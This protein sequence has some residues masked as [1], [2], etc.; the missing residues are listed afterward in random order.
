MK[1]LFVVKR[2]I[3][4][5]DLSDEAFV[6]WCA[7]RSIMQK[8]IKEYF[9]SYSM[10]GYA[11][12]GKRHLTRTEI[13]IVKKGYNDLKEKDYIK[14]KFPINSNDEIV[15]LSEL[16]YEKGKGYFS[17]LTDVEMQKIMNLK[18]IGKINHCRLLRYFTCMVGT[19]NR[20]NDIG[21]EYKGK[22]GGMA[23][24][25]FTE[26][27]GVSNK[28][29]SQYNQ[30]L[31]DNELLFIVRHKDF[32]QGTNAKGQSELREIPNTYSRWC[33]KDIAKKFSEDIHGYKYFKEQKNIKTEKANKNRGLAQKYNSFCKGKE[34]DIETIKAIYIYCENWNKN[35]LAYHNTQISLGYKHELQQKDM[36]VF[37]KYLLKVVDADDKNVKEVI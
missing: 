10:I 23:L 12:H 25:C 9:V 24:D 4:D 6:V 29:A 35:Q 28:T 7:L 32:L 27:I 26:L 1:K 8:D 36:S 17:D 37:D 22:I 19:F 16:Y 14:L 20:S 18:N 15:D 13:N 21:S 30:I 33:D 34:Y 3:E 31:E 2:V 11:L 5:K